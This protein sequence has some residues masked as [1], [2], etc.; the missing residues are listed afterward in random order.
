MFRSV[1]LTIAALALGGCRIVSQQELAALKNPPNPKMADVHQVFQ[2]KIIP[3]LASEAKPL[4]A[5]MKDLAAA[6]DFDS[7]C[8]AFGYRAQ[9]ENPCVFTV[10]VKGAV[11]N[12]NTTSRS[13]KMTVKD[14]SGLS[15]PVQIGPIIRG[16][17]LRDAYKGASYQDFNDQVLFGD[18]GRA[19]N[20]QASDQMKTLQPK[21]G[22]KLE[23]VGVFSSWDIPQTVPDITP[24]RVTRQ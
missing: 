7:A 4:D 23:V 22:D 2:Q 18:Y 19:I 5:L 12:V 16:T 10:L 14:V 6:K 8:Q 21:V 11:E 13:G 24:A 3:Q 15:A 20:N 1:W 9:A 17:A